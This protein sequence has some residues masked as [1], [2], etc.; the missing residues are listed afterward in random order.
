MVEAGRVSERRMRIV[1]GA[2]RLFLE[3]GYEATTVRQI[4]EEVGLKSGSLFSHFESKQQILAL[5]MDW[6]LRL[7]LER[8]DEAVE[9][10]GGS[11]E[12]LMALCRAHFQALLGE[13]ADALAIPLYEWRSLAPEA[14]EEIVRM[15]DAYEARWQEVLE[16]AVEEEVIHTEDLH[17]FRLF[18]LGAANS[19]VQW[20]RASGEYDIEALA[21]RFVA[22][23]LGES[24]PGGAH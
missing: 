6:G 15:R 23:V 11:R 22:F 3:N 9:V 4:A 13:A 17:M 16:E 7:A 14:R 18:V 21:E 2:A 20:Y 19:T 12:R 10:E 1:R 24:E 5:A 8:A